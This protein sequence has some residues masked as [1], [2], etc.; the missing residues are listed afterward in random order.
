[1]NVY[2]FKMNNANYL[3][4]DIMSLILNMRTEEM[5]KDKEKLKYDKIMESLKKGVFY[6]KQEHFYNEMEEKGLINDFNKVYNFLKNR[7]LWEI[8]YYY[9]NLL[10]NKDFYDREEG[11][12][13]T[14]YLNQYI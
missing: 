8:P 13:G 10:T 9:N 1:M 6:F 5:K 2:N 12:I 7:E 14:N 3:P 11:E 4:N